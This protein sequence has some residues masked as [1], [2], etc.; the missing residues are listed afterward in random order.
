ML[1]TRTAAID[2]AITASEGNQHVSERLRD[3]QR[4]QS[5]VVM[6]RGRPVAHVS[7]VEADPTREAVQDLLAFLETLPRRGAGPWRRED[8][9]G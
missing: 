9:Y 5:F 7:P 8:I 1:T 3:V 2:R 4:G 6:S